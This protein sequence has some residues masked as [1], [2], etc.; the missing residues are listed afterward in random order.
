MDCGKE[1]NSEPDPAGSHVRKPV[2]LGGGINP[3]W[4]VVPFIPGVNALAIW[5]APMVAGLKIAL[6]ALGLV[7]AGSWILNIQIQ[8]NSDLSLPLLEQRLPSWAGFTVLDLP[9]ISTIVLVVVY[10]VGLVHM[11][12][13]LTGR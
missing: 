13:R 12:R 10:Y 8:A 2:H 11:N 1:I 7:V 6:V 4:Y 3:I 9:Y 5:F